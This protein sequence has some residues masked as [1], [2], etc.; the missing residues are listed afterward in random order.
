MFYAVVKGTVVST[1][2]VESLNGVTLKVMTPCDKDKKE[3]GQDFI[4]VDPIGTRVGDLVMWVGK[5][6][7][8]MAITEAGIKNDFPIDA[9][10]TGIIDDIS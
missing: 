7:A 2:K 5:R 10:V 8:S 1:Q 6:E 9:A 4:A 3:N